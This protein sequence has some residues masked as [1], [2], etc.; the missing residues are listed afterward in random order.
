MKE[1]GNELLEAFVRR[2]L[3]ARSA[4]SQSSCSGAVAIAL[5]C[6]RCGRAR[7]QAGRRQSRQDQTQKAESENDKVTLIASSD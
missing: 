3:Q 2:R 7:E 1:Q 6:L 5:S 4:R